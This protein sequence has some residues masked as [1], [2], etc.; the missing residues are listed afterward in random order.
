VRGQSS[1]SQWHFHDVHVCLSACPSLPSKLCRLSA[2]HIYCTQCH[3]R[4]IDSRYFYH[5]SMPPTETRR[6][7]GWLVAETDATWFSNYK[8]DV[9]VD[10]DRRTVDT[11]TR[12]WALFAHRLGQS[13]KFPA[14]NISVRPAVAN[15]IFRG[16]VAAHLA[17]ADFLSRRSDGLELAAWFIAWS[18]RRVW[19]FQRGLEKRISLP[20]DVR[21]V[22]ALEV[23]PFHGI[24]LYKSK[25]TY[26]VA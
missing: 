10:T 24:A 9:S 6:E 7:K 23:S 2:V 17:P 1:S 16:F 11:R 8:N 20:S 22:N 3:R 15:W 19:T 25:F 5:D 21:D 13:P 4:T 26:L 18:G 12:T 14:A